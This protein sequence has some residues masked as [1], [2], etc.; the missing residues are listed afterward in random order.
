MKGLNQVIHWLEISQSGIYCLYSSPRLIFI[1]CLMLA[2]KICFSS[3]A[4]KLFFLEVKFLV[5]IWCTLLGNS[6]CSIRNY[7]D[8]VLF[9]CFP[10]ANRIIMI[11]LPSRA[12]LKVFHSFKLLDQV[13]PVESQRIFPGEVSGSANAVF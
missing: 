2:M 9:Y 10:V 4:E 8:A 1:Y 12:N 3:Y 7:V 6:R 11:A 5:C 13:A